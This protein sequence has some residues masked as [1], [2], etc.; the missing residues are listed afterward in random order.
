MDYD[1]ELKAYD[2]IFRAACGVGPGDRVLDV[3]CGGGATTCAAAR[4]AVS[5]SAVGVDL[6]ADAVALARRRAEV[7]GLRNV[8]FQCADAQTHRFR[9]GRFDLAISRFGTM[10]FGDPVAAFGNVARAVR[11]GGRLVMLVWQPKRQNEWAVAIDSVLGADNGADGPDAFSLGDPDSVT[12]ILESAGFI[13]VD[14]SEVR[15]SVYYGPD[16]NT[17]LEWVRGFTS[18]KIPLERLDP[19]AA[20]HTLGRLRALMAGHLNGD[21]VRFDSGAWIVTARRNPE[22]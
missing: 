2:E 20:E 12:S 5:G 8:G 11:P 14:L 19:V 4:V 21:G 17:A 1:T 18:T 13:H 7:E 15:Q 22:G 16:V 3:G 6:S 10:F 9:R